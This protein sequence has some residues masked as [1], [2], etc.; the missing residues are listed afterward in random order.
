MII[1]QSLRGPITAWKT[2]TH[3]PI[4]RTNFVIPAMLHR[5][6]IVVMRKNRIQTL[7]L[8]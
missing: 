2:H 5:K 7:A 8:Q 3:I 6:P 4:A 1:I